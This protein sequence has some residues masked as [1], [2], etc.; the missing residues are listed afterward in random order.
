MILARLLIFAQFIPKYTS[1]S[2]I[3]EDW[4]AV[5][6][7]I[8]KLFL[9]KFHERKDDREKEQAE[10][11][12]TFWEELDDFHNQDFFMSHILDTQ[13]QMRRLCYVYDVNITLSHTKDYLAELHI[14]VTPLLR[15][16]D[17]K[18]DRNW[19]AHQRQQDW[20]AFKALT[21]ESKKA[22]LG[23][24]CLLSRKVRSNVGPCAKGWWVMEWWWFHL[25]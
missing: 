16:Q 17:Q 22:N 3:H 8:A 20:K 24:C 11:M 13:P 6:W 7:I 2:V 9:S 5:E 25:V 12:H 19:K 23:I 14:T 15:L 18:A 21:R 1:T 10:L 4:E